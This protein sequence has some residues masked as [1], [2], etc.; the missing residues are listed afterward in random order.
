[1]EQLLGEFVAEQAELPGAPTVHLDLGP[2]LPDLD[3]DGP[4]IHQVLANLAGNTA[5]Y[6]GPEARL[7][8][9]ARRGGRRMVVVTVVDDG[10]GI[11]AEQRSHVF[12]RF[13]R[14][15]S[16]RESRIPGNGLGL[17]LAKRVVEAHGGWIRLDAAPRGTS[18]SFALPAIDDGDGTPE[19]VA[20]AARLREH[21]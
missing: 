3:V 11:D 19:V 16:V 10:P 7:T 4:R 20:H 15:R 12:E 21:E 13:Y 14:G 9:R 17:Y 5:K 2:D 8:V 18:I 6:A 1:V